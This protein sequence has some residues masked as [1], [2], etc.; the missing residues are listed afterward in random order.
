[1]NINR[2]RRK[3][4]DGF[5]VPLI[6]TRRGEGY[7]LDAPEDSRRDDDKD[8]HEGAGDMRGGAGETRGGH[9]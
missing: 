5:G 4:D 2:L 6:H 8:G 9:V 7:V 1:V 3:I